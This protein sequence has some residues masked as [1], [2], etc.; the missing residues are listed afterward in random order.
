MTESS[1]ERLREKNAELHKKVAHLTQR[2]EE[3]EKAKRD[4]RDAREHLRLMLDALPD[5]LFELD[6]E[7]RIRDFRAPHAELLF[8][9]PTVFLGKRFTDVLPPEVSSVLDSAILRARA[10]GRDTGACY[11]LPMP[12]GER[13][14]E[15]SVA[16][17]T[18]KRRADHRTVILI[19]DITARRQTE[20]DLRRSEQRYRL[21]SENAADVIWLMDAK[22]LRFTYVSPSVRR[23]RGYEAE[24]VLGQS[25]AEVVS[26]DAY[27][28]ITDGLPRRVAAFEAGD[29]SQRVNRAE[30]DQ[31]RRDGSMVPTEVVTTLVT[32]ADGHV[33]EIL[34]VSR[35]ITERRRAEEARLS[36]ERQL[37]NAQKLDSL[38]IL[39]G[40]VAHDFSNILTAILGNADLAQMELPGDSPAREC[41]DD[42]TSAARRAAE[43]CRQMLAYSGK[44]RFVVEPVDVSQ[45]VGAMTSLLEVSIPK[46]AALHCRLPEGLP[47][48]EADATQVR[49]VVLNLAVNAAEA[50]GVLPGTVS[51]ETGEMHCDAAYL[52]DG[53]PSGAGTPGRYVFLEVRDT[54]CGIET[55]NLPR[56]FD[57][58]FTTKFTG[59]GLGLPAVLGIVRGHH[60]AIKVTTA[61]GQG[62]TVRVLFP[63]FEREERAD[64][65]AQDPSLWRGSGTVLV[66][67]DEEGVRKLAK[68][69]LE[70]L[71]FTVR[72]ASDGMEAVEIFGAN[73]ADIS[74][75]L[76]DLTMP[77]MGGAETFR[78]L[79]ALAPEIRVILSSGYLIDQATEGFGSHGLSGFV[80]KPYQLNALSQVMKA[81]LTW[82]PPTG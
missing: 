60:G 68:A 5:L 56:I 41:M 2:V 44:G 81:A 16:A 54:G 17:T 55:A 48:I 11:S 45:L 27:R 70:R 57:P 43:L 22:T 8:V 36:I 13:W 6:R 23:L 46:K 18:A 53:V 61:P 74:C 26:P 52:T 50:I 24:E 10:S 77:R 39:A 4:L 38:G 80:Q 47:S 40:G 35:D 32:G 59:R 63:A 72:L 64:S 29:E 78:A 20:E 42:I 3:L 33:T 30:V 82:R 69:M 79:R 58:F 21:L 62:T 73:P 15:L 75:V 49:Q 76:L 65:P 67:D 25:L 51:V 7:G 37:L 28:A 14:F 31:P 19:R 9:P 1:I 71:G 66:V 34:G 12:D